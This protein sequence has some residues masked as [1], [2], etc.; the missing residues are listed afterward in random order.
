MTT[1][2]IRKMRKIRRK[3]N[4]RYTAKVLVALY[5]LS[6][7]FSAFILIKPSVTDAAE[8]VS[9]K[10]DL[11]LYIISPYSIRLEWEDDI[12]YE[13]AYIIQRAIDSADFKS[14]ASVRANT[15]TYVDYNI[16][17]GHIYTYRIFYKNIH[18]NLYQHTVEVSTS[19]DLI[20]KPNTLELTPV[21]SGQ[22][23]I[24]WTYPGYKQ[25]DTVIERKAD[26]ET[27]WK[28]IYRA[29]AGTFNYI[30][31]GLTPGL[32]YYYRIKAA[33]AT[34]IYSDYYPSKY[35]ESI[36]TSLKAPQNLFGYAV[37]STRIYLSWEYKSDDENKDEKGK[38]NKRIVD[39]FELER[40][41]EN[42][43]YVLI[44]V[45]PYTNNWYQDSGLETGKLYT[46]R[47]RA[48]KG[49]VYS[50]YS[51][52]ITINCGYINP[53]VALSARALSANSI[54]LKWEN[55]GLDVG[56]QIEIWRKS[57]DYQEWDLFALLDRSYNKFIDKNVEEGKKYSYKLRSVI[58]Y[59]NTYSNYSNEVSAYA[60]DYNAPTDIDYVVIDKDR[61]QLYWNYE[62]DF[63]IAENAD[64]TNGYDSTNFKSGF[65]IE[66]KEG[67]FGQWK[68]LARVSSSVNNYFVRGLDENKTYYF[69]VR[70][71][72]DNAGIGTYS[73]E[74]KVTTRLPDTPEITS[75]EALSPSKIELKWKDTLQ[76]DDPDSGY[77]IE[78]KLNALNH[79]TVIAVLPSNSNTYIDTDLSPSRRY[80][81]RIKAFN[82]AGNS[83]YS[84]NVF[85]ITK[86]FNYFEDVPPSHPAS[87]ALYELVGRGAVKG[88]KA[89]NK[90]GKVVEMFYPDEAITRGEFIYMLM[91]AFK[92]E[93]K[94]IGSFADVT[95]GHWFYKE[96]MTAKN[97]GIITGDELNYFYPENPL[98]YDEMERII[99][100]ALKTVGRNVLYQSGNIDGK[101]KNKDEFVTKGEAA[102][103]VYNIID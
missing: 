21:T 27:E 3:L 19:S 8:V 51:E 23:E 59:N 37:S 2:K 63:I 43:D 103:V 91:K 42:E 99:N 69:K 18:G 53:P 5:T 100:K 45:I 24:K 11:K 66:M 67:L 65:I 61:I 39:Y 85:A 75:I 32:K 56:A 35:G 78:R 90:E 70:A 88:Q 89:V 46:Y 50:D 33:T 17:P 86:A 30:D 87:E 49:T 9:E 31:A 93:G 74:I 12:S 81:Y 96:V 82:K 98:T 58:A 4:R 34:N 97:L 62:D 10:K 60:L 13:T 71:V 16:S 47:V 15:T 95:Y 7:L 1:R 57:E 72:N 26:K 22:V 40:K 54:E 25:Y 6:I 20:S 94:A 76:D 44:A 83:Q 84:K 52:E 101:S 36:F 28:V 79:Y 64:A 92:L 41:T 102:I 73:R 29:P 38:S 77:I 68:E 55:R 48:K 80:D 14:I